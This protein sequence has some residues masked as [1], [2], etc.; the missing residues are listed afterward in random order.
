MQSIAV[1]AS[2]IDDGTIGVPDHHYADVQMRSFRELSLCRASRLSGIAS[3]AL[4]E[5]LGAS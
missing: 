4:T 2:I 5:P 3:V 1:V